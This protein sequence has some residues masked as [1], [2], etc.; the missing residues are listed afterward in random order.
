MR[1]TYFNTGRNREGIHE[2]TYYACS[3]PS[4][5]IESD[6]S[7]PTG[8]RGGPVIQTKRYAQTRR[9]ALMSED[10]KTVVLAHLREAITELMKEGDYDAILYVVAMMK[11][12]H[13]EAVR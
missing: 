10:A 11:R 4:R 1:L 7:P 5:V 6:A 3:R 2:T 9:D 12:V 8:D 13:D